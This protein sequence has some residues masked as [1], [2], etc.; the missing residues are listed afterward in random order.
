L[1]STQA[2]LGKDLLSE[3]TGTRQTSPYTAKEIRPEVSPS[4]GLDNGQLLEYLEVLAADCDKIVLGGGGAYYQVDFA[5]AERIAQL[6]YIR[7]VG[8]VCY[9][10]TLSSL[11][12]AVAPFLWVSEHSQVALSREPG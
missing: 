1:A 5:V 8:G 12:R 4:L 6:T 2:I 7:K 3:A 11:A 9:S 10:R